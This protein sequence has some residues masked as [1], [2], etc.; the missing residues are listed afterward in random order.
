MIFHIFHKILHWLMTVLKGLYGKFLFVK[1]HGRMQ[2]ILRSKVLKTRSNMQN[3]VLI[4]SSLPFHTL[5][6]MCMCSV[7]SNKINTCRLTSFRE[8]LGLYAMR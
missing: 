4:M 2:C 1:K 8:F 5:F 6:G 7:Y 3:C